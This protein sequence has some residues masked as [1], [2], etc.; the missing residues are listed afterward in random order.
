MSLLKRQTGS[1]MGEGHRGGVQVLW[2]GPHWRTEG[3]WKDAAFC[4]AV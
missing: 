4:W 2:E 1:T 3:W